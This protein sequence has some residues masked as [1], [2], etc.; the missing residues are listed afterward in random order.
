MVISNDDLLYACTYAV[1]CVLLILLQSTYVILMDDAFLNSTLTMTSNIYVF[2][3][4][5]V[6]NANIESEF[7]VILC[8]L[9]K[10]ITNSTFD[11]KMYNKTFSRR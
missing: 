11:T 3:V 5:F 4:C 10:L 9:C 1:Q 8:T 6:L 2:R 7:F